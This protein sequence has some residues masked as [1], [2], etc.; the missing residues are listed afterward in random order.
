MSITAD[1]ANA[2]VHHYHNCADLCRSNDPIRAEVFTICAHMCVFM[3]CAAMGSEAA[4]IAL[5][6]NEKEPHP[7]KTS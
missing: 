1:R 2:Y 4:A 6:Q 3:R 7:Y 5:I